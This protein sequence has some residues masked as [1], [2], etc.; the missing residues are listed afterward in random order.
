MITKSIIKDYAHRRC[1]YLTKASLDDNSLLKLIENFLEFGTKED[2]E[3]AIEDSDGRDDN[4]N[5]NED[6]TLDIVEI[7]RDYPY[8]RG[9]IEKLIV[10]HAQE[11]PLYG[12]LKKYEDTQ[13]TARLSRRYIEL[14][15]GKDVCKRCDVNDF[16]VESLNQA[17]IVSRTKEYLADPSVKVLFEG[18]IEHN[19]LRARFDVLIKEDDGTL[20]LIEAKGSNSAL[21][22]PKGC[23]EIDTGIKEGYLYDL[24]FQYYIYEKAGLNL[25]RLGY[26]YL[27]KDFTYGD[28]ANYPDLSDEQV[29]NLFKVVFALNY[30]KPRSKADPIEIPIK[31]YLDAEMYVANDKNGDPIVFQIEELIFII[32]SI[33]KG[34]NPEAV[35][36][37]HCV[38]GGK[39]PFL[40]SCFEDAE[41]YNSIFKLTRWI[42]Y[43]GVWTRSKKL[44]DQGVMH[45]SEVPTQVVNLY[46]EESQKDDLVAYGCARM[47]FKFENE[48][49]NKPFNY[50][51]HKKLL[52]QILYADYDNENVDYLVFF[53]F[54]SIQNPVPLMKDAHPWQQIVTQYSMHIVKKGYDLT[55][56]DFESGRGGGCSHYEFI[57]HP[58]KDK[59]ENPEFDLFRVLKRQ[60]EDFGIDPMAKNYR[61]VVFNQSFEQTRMNEF[62]RLYTSNKNTDAEILSFV[63]NFNDNVV[64]LLNFFTYGS[65]YGRDF[66]GRGSLKVVQPTLCQDPDVLA[67]YNSINLPF[68]FANSLDYHKEGALVYNGGICLDLYKALLVRNHIDPTD[69][70]PDEQE[71]LNQALAYCKIDSWGTVIIYDILKHVS[72]GKIKLK[73]LM[74]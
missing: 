23:P 61:V 21:K 13:V 40:L 11:N 49:K 46:N 33:R 53:D 50:V 69:N 9:D 45:I 32:D 19:N 20:T 31:D 24:A 44:M 14:K 39:C 47:Q 58:S 64:D 66:K 17:F 12:L 42:A 10:K 15:Y 16:G 22:H 51:V 41:D 37:Y 6:K 73:A 5:P 62:V 25:S 54:E 43:G 26:L 35:R 28:G 65:I 3:E 68:D 71:M 2:L 52:D 4:D 29:L 48:W 67:Y 74:L 56:H 57:G 1:P 38:K 18:Q 63:Q 27:N 55:K 8:L 7:M 70:D 72:D 36:H 30:K 59:Y 60:L 34:T